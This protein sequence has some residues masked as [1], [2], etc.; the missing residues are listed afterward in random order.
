MFSSFETG[1]RK[2]SWT[3]FLAIIAF[4]Q[5]DDNTRQMLENIEGLSAGLEMILFSDLRNND[6]RLL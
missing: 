6:L 3:V 2:M 5:N 4:F 1:K